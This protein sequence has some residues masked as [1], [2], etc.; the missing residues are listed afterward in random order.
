MKKIP[1][2]IVILCSVAVVLCIILAAMTIG[3]KKDDSQ[4]PVGGTSG[5]V[6]TTER[7]ADVEP[8]ELPD[9]TG[10]AQKLGFEPKQVEK[11]SDEF[12]L[13]H[14][15]DIEN[16]VI[17][18]YQTHLAANGS[19]ML[20][21]IEKMTEEE[22]QAALP[23]ESVAQPIEID[24]RNTVFANRVLYKVSEDR[25]VS[26]TFLKEEEEGTAVIVRTEIDNEISEIQTLDWYEDNCRYE[27]YAD[28]QGLTAEEMTELAH[29]Y[30]TN[31]Q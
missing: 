7:V 25:E 18:H 10:I 12:V 14:V 20:L 16:G 2:E 24:G 22:Y 19:R 17:Y 15:E 4:K 8:I 11:L 29:N 13:R 26:D 6:E 1:K 5:T 31:A 9:K 28:Y 23:K 21:K 3:S 27:L 30:F